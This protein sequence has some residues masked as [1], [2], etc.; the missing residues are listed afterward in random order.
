[1]AARAPMATFDAFTLLTV[2]P[3]RYV[4]KSAPAFMFDA[5]K[6]ERPDPGPTNAADH[7]VPEIFIVVTFSL[8]T[9]SDWIF[10]LLIW[11][12]DANRLCA[13]A[14]TTFND[15]M[16]DVDETLSV[17]RYEPDDTFKMAAFAL[18]VKVPVTAVRLENPAAPTN[19]D[20][21]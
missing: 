18:A 13:F 10:E 2:F 15:A 5:F 12:E 11:A 16:L 14:E 9:L 20:V 7:A 17:V 4:P 6:L 3:Q 19:V 1:M 8:D 21:P